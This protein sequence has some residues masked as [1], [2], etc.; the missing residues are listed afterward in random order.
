MSFL[1]MAAPLLI[2]KVGHFG[3]RSFRVG[4]DQGLESTVASPSFLGGTESSEL[5]HEHTDIIGVGIA[6]SGD[7]LFQVVRGCQLNTLAKIGGALGVKTK[8]L[9]DEVEG[10]SSQEDTNG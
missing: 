5:V 6:A 7:R 3:N 8:R 9:Y 4:I 2:E 1:L 10:D